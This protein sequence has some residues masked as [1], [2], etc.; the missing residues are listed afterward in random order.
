MYISEWKATFLYLYTNIY[1]F[2]TEKYKS[3]GNLNPVLPISADSFKMNGG[4]YGGSGDGSWYV[5]DNNSMCKT[6]LWADGSSLICAPTPP[7]SFNPLSVDIK[8]AHGSGNYIGD[9]WTHVGTL[10]PDDAFCIGNSSRYF[11]VEE[12]GDRYSAKNN[13]IYCTMAK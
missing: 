4:S 8:M 7:K 2:F 6:F 11:Y 9:G 1:N 5:E 12:D 13:N 3:D 10:D